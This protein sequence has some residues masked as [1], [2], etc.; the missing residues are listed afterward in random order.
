MNEISKMVSGMFRCIQ[1]WRPAKVNRHS[2]STPKMKLN[3]FHKSIF[4][5]IF[6][7]SFGMLFFIVGH[8]FSSWL[9]VHYMKDSL[10]FTLVS[11]IISSSLI[12]ALVCSSV[13]ILSSKINLSWPVILPNAIEFSYALRKLRIFELDEQI[14][15]VIKQN[16]NVFTS[17]VELSEIHKENVRAKKYENFSDK[18]KIKNLLG[19]RMLCLD[20]DEYEQLVQEYKQRCSIEES[21]ILMEKEQELSALKMTIASISNDKAKLENELEF[22]RETNAK[23]QNQQRMQPA[24]GQTRVDRLREERLYWAVFTP[25]IGRLIDK[26]PKGKLYTM[27]EIEAAFAEE[28]ERRTDLR[29]RMRKLTGSETANPSG[30]VLEAVKAE[31]KEAGLFSAGGRPHKNL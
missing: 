22:F 29:E 10:I 14:R 25:L 28:W 23:L 6:A 7:V 16:I 12:I 5:F 21:V 3:I 13:I 4:S 20:A 11:Y 27:P 1:N 17:Y 2:A 26:A 31:F 15:F 8:F 18:E 30:S 19:G 24:Q 9:F